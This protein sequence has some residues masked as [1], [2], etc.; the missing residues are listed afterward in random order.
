MIYLKIA[1]D[2]SGRYRYVGFKV[3]FVGRFLVKL[4]P[5]QKF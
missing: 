4:V 5:D 3:Y 2:P 1:E